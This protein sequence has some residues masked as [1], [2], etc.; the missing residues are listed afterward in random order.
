MP[1]KGRGLYPYEIRQIALRMYPEALEDSDE[2]VPAVPTE[3]KQVHVKFRENTYN[4][5]VDKIAK[6][7]AE[8]RVARGV[9]AADT[10]EELEE[11]EDFLQSSDRELSYCDQLTYQRLSSVYSITPTK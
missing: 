10:M 7:M 5:V 1:T 11:Y 8:Q 4:F 2:K 3:W 9:P 6:T